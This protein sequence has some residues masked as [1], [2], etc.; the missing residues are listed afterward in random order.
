MGKER[1]PP[2]HNATT[3]DGAEACG[4]KLSHGLKLR[5]A[6]GDGVQSVERAAP[7]R[8]TTDRQRERRRG[9]AVRGRRATPP[10]YT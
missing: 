6:R 5:L 1:A 3:K 8:P 9:L 2:L 7:P 10:P 4:K